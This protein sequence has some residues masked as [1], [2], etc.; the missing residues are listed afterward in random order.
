LLLTP[1]RTRQRLK[2]AEDQMEVEAAAWVAAVTAA[3]LDP[4]PPTTEPVPGA[5]GTIAQAENGVQLAQLQTNRRQISGAPQV[6]IFR[7][8]VSGIPALVNHRQR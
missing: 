3:A 6:M 5:R 1:G 4:G 2:V 8:Q 7:R